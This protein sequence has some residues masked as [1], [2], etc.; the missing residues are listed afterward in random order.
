[1]TQYTS[2]RSIRNRL[3]LLL[4]RAFGIAVTLLVLFGASYGLVRVGYLPMPGFLMKR[5]AFMPLP[6]GTRDG[7]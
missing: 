6:A 7:R 2:V 5:P 4:L 1:M 3:F